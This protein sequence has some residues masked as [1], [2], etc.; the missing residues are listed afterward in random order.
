MRDGSSF[1]AFSPTFGSGCSV[2]TSVTLKSAGSWSRKLI[3][4]L[5][6]GPAGNGGLLS[7]GTFMPMREAEPPRTRV[8]A[9]LLGCHLGSGALVFPRSPASRPSLASHWADPCHVT[10]A[11]CKGSWEPCSPCS[12]ARCSANK[13]RRLEVKK[14]DDLLTKELSVSHVSK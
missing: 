2:S 11:S 13:V 9:V 1:S 8:P 3:R 5:R 10:T 12:V 14:G 7:V 4:G 6:R